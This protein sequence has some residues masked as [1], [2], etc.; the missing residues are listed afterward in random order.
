MAAKGNFMVCFIV[1]ATLG[2]YPVRDLFR[3]LLADAGPLPAGF[4]F[5]RFFFVKH[6]FFGADG[7]EG[8]QVNFFYI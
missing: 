6:L 8:K 7:H 1:A 5:S 2:D 3:F 4:L